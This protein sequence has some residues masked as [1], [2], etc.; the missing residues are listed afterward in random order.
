MDLES[1]LF[2]VEIWTLG[3]EESVLIVRFN[4]T[5]GTRDNKVS[6]LSRCPHFGGPLENISLHS[7]A[8]GNRGEGNGREVLVLSQ[9]EA[10]LNRFL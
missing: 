8:T 2:S 1:V 5:H 7:R 4:S 6:R 9:C 10:V 3:I